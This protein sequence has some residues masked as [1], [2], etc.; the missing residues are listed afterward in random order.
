MVPIV[1]STT[2][3]PSIDCPTFSLEDRELSFS[4][5]KAPVTVDLSGEE[6]TYSACCEIFAAPL[7]S[8]LELRSLY[9]S[10]CRDSCPK[11]TAM[12]NKDL[13]SL[14][15]RVQQLWDDACADATMTN[16]DLLPRWMRQR[17]TGAAQARS[18]TRSQSNSRKRPNRRSKCGDESSDSEDDLIDDL[19]DSDEDGEAQ[20]KRRR[21]SSALSG[22]DNSIELGDACFE[23]GDELHRNEPSS[24]ATPVS[25]PSADEIIGASKDVEVSD[26]ELAAE[27]VFVLL[28]DVGSGKSAV[29]HSLARQIGFRVTELNA[30]A[31]RSSAVVKHVLLETAERAPLDHGEAEAAM[32]LIVVDEAD[33]LLEPEEI[34]MHTALL[35]HASQARC[36]VLLT[37]ETLPRALYGLVHGYTN[38]Q[39]RI[40]ASRVIVASVIRKIGSQLCEEGL[41]DPNQEHWLSTIVATTLPLVTAGDLRLSCTLLLHILLGMAKCDGKKSDVVNLCSPTKQP[42][43]R[44]AHVDDVCAGEV[45]FTAYLV[46]QRQ[47]FALFDSLRPPNCIPNAQVMPV[48]EVSAVAFRPRIDTVH[49]PAYALGTNALSDDDA[50]F[51]LR[52]EG[53]NFIQRSPS[54]AEQPAEVIVW[55]GTKRY[56]AEGLLDNE[57]R[58]LVT[59]RQ[60]Q[61]L[62]AGV[63]RVVVE[64]SCATLYSERNGIVSQS[65]SPVFSLPATLC[66]FQENEE[67]SRTRELLPR[68]LLRTLQ[69]RSQS[70]LLFKAQG[71]SVDL[72]SRPRQHV[73]WRAR[74]G[75]SGVAVLKQHR[76]QL[77]GSSASVENGV[78]DVCHGSGDDGGEDDGNDEGTDG[79]GD[80]DDG[81]EIEGDACNDGEG[82]EVPVNETG[83]DVHHFIRIVQGETREDGRRDFET[84]NDNSL[85]I[86]R[87]A[88]SEG[89][90]SNLDGL[91]PSGDTSTTTADG[92]SVQL[93]SLDTERL[94]KLRVSTDDETSIIRL[95]APFSNHDEAKQELFWL[96]QVGQAADVLG[97]LDLLGTMQ[98]RQYALSEEMEVSFETDTP[99]LRNVFSAFP[100]E[101]ED[102]NGASLTRDVLA[103]LGETVG[104]VMD[105]R[106]LLGLDSCK[107]AQ[108]SF[109]SS[110]IQMTERRRRI[111]EIIACNSTLQSLLSS[112]CT[113]TATPCPLVNQDLTNLS[114]LTGSERGI[115]TDIGPYFG[116][117]GNAASDADERSRHERMAFARRASR[118]SSR[119]RLNESEDLHPNHSLTMGISHLRNAVRLRSDRDAAELLTMHWGLRPGKIKL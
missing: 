16:G 109:L 99:G 34:T 74:R 102:V 88:D 103:A 44:I 94:Q 116:I 75:G 26:A 56:R 28:G 86:P 11:D 61:S 101:R 32:G 95:D 100:D 46:Q 59:S 65:L 53:E 106:R 98:R 25:D 12:M 77:L 91:A 108:W 20:G 42:S 27:R 13:Q 104:T 62:G 52:I 113:A 36:P 119:P 31:L 21:L 33:L 90:R 80:G 55:I 112:Q 19:V 111:R 47:D 118:S 58:V 83:V 22:R 114:G 71:D 84:Q 30:G 38:V 70:F 60:L 54:Q 49:P 4:T 51:I 23:S 3:T 72:G 39:R 57:I 40:R 29:V 78:D 48:R 73:H 85:D 45:R 96:E 97:E 89:G 43:S 35:R 107:N 50:V 82:V 1:S 63:H 14:I 64:A 37:C 8:L 69:S 117:L 18:G 9:L 5:E 41:I 2:H 93:K 79:I 10:F 6:T 115:W 24:A 105:E 7:S 92:A 110:A 87:Q 76:Q 81:D 15:Q 66:I 17:F 68:D 67:A